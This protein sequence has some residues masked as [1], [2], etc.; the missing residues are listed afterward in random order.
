MSNTGCVM[1]GE[2]TF[3][4]G[5]DFGQVNFTNTGEFTYNAMSNS[6]KSTSMMSFDFYMSE[7]AMT[8]LAVELERDLADELELSE[9]YSTNNFERILSDPDLLIEYE[10]FGMFEKLPKELS[11]S[12]YFYEVK[13]EWDSESNSL[14]SKNALGLGNINDNQINKL[15]QGKIEL[16]KESSG[17]FF[18]IYF[19]TDLGESYFFSY[20]NEL[21]ISRSTIDAYNIEI[22]EVKTQQRKLDTKKDELGYQYDL[23]SEDDVDNFKKR[24]FR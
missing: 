11:K 2:G 7:K 24:F 20:S 1:K 22:L 21:M 17:D 8:Q 4:F 12:L 14:I 10:M 19:D 9:K 6:L 16:A 5:L 23:S 13:L 18:N 3:N 15:F